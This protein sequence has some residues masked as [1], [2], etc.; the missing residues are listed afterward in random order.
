M[1]WRIRCDNASSIARDDGVDPVVVDIAVEDLGPRS[2][3]GKA[4]R[5]VIPGPLRESGNY[6][7][8]LT[9][10]FEPAMKRDHTVQI[11]NM[12]W[13]HVVAR[14]KGGYSQVRGDHPPRPEPILLANGA[15]FGGNTSRIYLS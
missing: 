12:K 9:C 13:V 10:T 1:Q 4:D 3:T 6:H 15:T 11:V 5:V 7:D 14:T 2:R 8:I